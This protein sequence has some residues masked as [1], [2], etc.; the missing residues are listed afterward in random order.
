VIKRIAFKEF[1]ENLVSVRF[2]IAF[3]MCMTLIPLATL[4]SINN[5]QSK[6]RVYD[7][8]KAE[9]EENS[10]PKVYS[11]LRPEIIKPP[12][13]LSIFSNGIS[14]NVGNKVKIRLGEKQLFTTGTSTV[15]ENPFTNRFLALDFI[16]VLSIVFSLIG[17]LFTYDICTRERE[18]GT[19]K[20]VFSNPVSRGDVLAGKVFGI[21]LTILPILLASFAVGIIIIFSY[22][23]ISFPFHDWVRILILLL[24]SMFYCMLF[25][26]IGVYISS[27]AKTSTLSIILCLFVWII[28]LFAVPNIAGYLAQSMFKVRSYDSVQRAMTEIDNEY[29]KKT[30]EYRNKIIAPDFKGCYW[31]SWS[32]DD[33]LLQIFGT[34]KATYEYHCKMN[35]YAEPLRIDYADKK[36]P[37]Q[38]AYFEEVNK[39]R[40]IGT[41]LSYLSPSEVFKNIS[42]S[43]CKTDFH[44]HAEFIMKTR[45]YREELIRFFRDEKLFGSYL[46]FTRVPPEKWRDDPEFCEFKDVEKRYDVSEIDQKYYPP[47]DLSDVPKFEYASLS[48]HDSM[49]GSVFGIAGLIVI[50][51]IIFYLSFLSFV[52]YDIR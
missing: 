50:S 1:Y 33:G 32:E 46:Y 41:L 43:L 19:F 52:K 24:I 25:M 17:L 6:V 20:Q 44:S 37:I 11:F 48:I 30:S 51:V 39:Q 21:F 42:S 13:P 26:I 4:I 16:T 27:K 36:W 45:I 34:V 29:D 35:A 14:F 15:R 22:S 49:K 12:E 7:V 3:V 10:H 38:Q 40:K 8:E 23:K 28:L 31:N 2:I 5:Y 9:A 47:L 18:Q